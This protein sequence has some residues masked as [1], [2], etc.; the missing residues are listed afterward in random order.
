M[1][2]DVLHPPFLPFSPSLSARCCRPRSADTD[3]GDLTCGGRPAAQGH[4]AQDAKTY[5]SWGVDYLKEDSCHASTDHS[6]AFTQ[7]GKMRDGLNA[8]GRPILFS[9][10]GWNAWYAPVG[11]TIGNAWRTGPDD[12]NW[13]GVVKNI[14]ILA[15]LAEYAGPGG[16][17]DPCLLLSQDW[18]GKMIMTELQIKAQFSMWAVVSAPLLISG[19]V[20]HMTDETL[21][22]YSNKKVIAVSQDPM[23]KAGSRVAGG[24]MSA[25]HGK[26]ANCTNVWAKPLST[27]AVSM[28]FIN[29][30]TAATKVCCD[31]ACMK[32]AGLEA[33]KNTQAQAETD[34][35]AAATHWRVEDLWSDEVNQVE[36]AAG[37]LCTTGAL[38]AE[39]GV[40]MVSVTM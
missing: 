11:K 38:P 29:T 6:A 30:G 3:R 33:M 22:T 2:K 8:T 7:Y 21:A 36:V 35:A 16:W 25:C 19:S 40:Q 20:T 10:C 17:N 27:K 32:V 18:S 4:E 37:P 23:G 1:L 24:D 12:S 13:G 26:T 5:A 28:V 15:P 14:D 9:L 31:A 39:G 34:G